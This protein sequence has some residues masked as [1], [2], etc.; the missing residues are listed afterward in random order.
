M[1]AVHRS[2]NNKKDS[3]IL[4]LLSVTSNLMVN[5]NTVSQ[6][7][8]LLIEA[9]FKI[10]PLQF[11]AMFSF[12][13]AA[14]IV[15]LFIYVF[16]FTLCL[17]VFLFSGGREGVFLHFSP[18][19]FVE[20]SA[21]ISFLWYGVQRFRNNCQIQIKN[22]WSGCNIELLNTNWDLSDGYGTRFSSPPLLPLPLSAPGVS[23]CS[24]NNAWVMSALGRRCSVQR[25]STNASHNDHVLLPLCTPS[26]SSTPLEIWVP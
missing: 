24:Q 12:P 7:A 5:K 1:W 8:K 19:T 20:F 21:L 9:Q 17:G 23:L 4:T 3:L 18:F 6:V 15:D 2:I 16:V 22:G 14:P 25:F 13:A 10:S 26:T 11:F